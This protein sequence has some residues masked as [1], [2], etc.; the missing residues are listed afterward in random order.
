MDKSD[1]IYFSNFEADPEFESIYD[2][3]ELYNLEFN[4]TPDQFG[5]ELAVEDTDEFI[6]DDV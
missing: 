3:D 4:E 2:Y 6:W 5:D 1:K